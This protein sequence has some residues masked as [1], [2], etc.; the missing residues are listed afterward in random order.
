MS[1]L[2]SHTGR[3]IL[4]GSAVEVATLALTGAVAISE[5]PDG[6]QNG[7]V[8]DQSWGWPPFA[9]FGLGTAAA[10]WAAIETGKSTPAG[11]SRTRTASRAARRRGSR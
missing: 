2:E 6:H 8:T 9:V 3:G 11:H 1:K 4:V 5:Q 10:L 7:P